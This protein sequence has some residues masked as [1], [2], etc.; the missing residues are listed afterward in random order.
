MSE[1]D[2]VKKDEG[3]VDV[4]MIVVYSENYTSVQH[5]RIPRELDA[6]G[7][8]NPLVQQALL[9]TVA[10]QVGADIGFSFRA[11]DVQAVRWTP[12][13]PAGMSVSEHVSKNHGKMHLLLMNAK[14]GAVGRMKMMADAVMGLTSELKKKDEEIDRLKQKVAELEQF[15]DHFAAFLDAQHQ[16]RQQPQQ[17]DTP[18]AEEAV[19]K[20]E[21]AEEKK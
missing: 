1:E 10:Q 2:K 7:P 4:D 19:P 6:L 13:C 15:R 5:V 16:Q 18:K 14:S 8:R 21:E 9:G 11:E 20:Q 12:E 3:S 17:E